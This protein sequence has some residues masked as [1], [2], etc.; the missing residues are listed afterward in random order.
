MCYLFGPPPFL[1]LNPKV[2]QPEARKVRQK[3]NLDRKVGRE[4]ESKWKGVWRRMRWGDAGYCRWVGG[5]RRAKH[6]KKI[7]LEE[8]EE[9]ANHN[10]N[11]Q[12][13]MVAIP[14]V[15]LGS[16]VLKTLSKPIASRL[17]QQAGIH[18]KFRNFIINIAQVPLLAFSFM[19]FLISPFLYSLKVIFF[20][21]GEWE[22]LYWPLIDLLSCIFGVD[23]LSAPINWLGKENPSVN[24]LLM[25]FKFLL[26]NDF[27]Q[28]K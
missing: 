17:K 21:N 22:F 24:D 20:W 11:K 5:R 25:R 19:G 26:F 10:H 18:P 3:A 27:P 8:T 28:T 15:K 9:E 2:R 1:N 12:W 13:S 23:L 16:L 7:R 14:V 4:R 6:N